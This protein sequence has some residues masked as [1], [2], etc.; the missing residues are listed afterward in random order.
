MKKEKYYPP[1]HA[2]GQFHCPHCGVY[3]KQFWANIK[4]SENYTNNFN[5]VIVNLSQFNQNLDHNWTISA[6]EHCEKIIIWLSNEIVYPKKMI[7]DL[8]NKDLSEDIKKDYLEAAIIFNDSARSSAALLRLALQKL[9]IQLGEKGK[10]IN[11]DIKN[12]VK[13]GLNPQIQ[14]SLDILRITGNN[15]V[16]PGEINVKEK[17]ELVLKLFELINFIAEKMIT[18]PKEIEEFYNELPNGAKD[19]IAKRDS[20]E[21]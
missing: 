7:V 17:S 18:E 12:L 6:C 5:N 11:D 13:K 2:T 20:T 9:C 14:K 15:A 1:K 4:A 10:N 16:H 3:A 19:Q 8:P 21:K